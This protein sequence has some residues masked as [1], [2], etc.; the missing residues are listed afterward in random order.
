MF[1]L[2][3]LISFTYSSRVFKNKRI[4]LEVIFG[5]Q[6]ELQYPK[7]VFG[8]KETYTVFSNFLMAKV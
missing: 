6:L 8:A 7:E 1:S 4:S 3:E 2:Y 5:Y